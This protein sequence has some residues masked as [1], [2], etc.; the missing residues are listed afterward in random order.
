MYSKN[1][2]GG[3]IFK[4]AC[5]LPLIAACAPDLPQ[6]L[7]VS[8]GEP[9]QPVPADEWRPQRPTLDLEVSYP[10][11]EADPEEPERRTAKESPGLIDEADAPRKTSTQVLDLSTTPPETVEPEPGSVQWSSGIGGPG[12]DAAMDVAADGDG[13]F[14][15]VGYFSGVVDFGCGAHT[16]S[17]TYD[18]F[19]VKQSASGACVWSRTAGSASGMSFADA[20]AIGASGAIYVIGSFYDSVAFSTASLVSNG[21][22][23]VFVAE[24]S[25]AGAE[26][27]ASSFGGTNEDY[28]YALDADASGI[29]LGGAFYGDLTVGETTLTSNGDADAFAVKLDLSGTPMWAAG[30][31][32]GNWDAVNDLALDGTGVVIAGS[33]QNAV[34][35]GGGTVTAAGGHD[36][37]I[38]RRTSDGTF[39]WSATFGDTDDDVATSVDL[40]DAGSMFVGG[41][42]SGTLDLGGGPLV[43]TGS[44]SGFVS[45]FDSD[46]FFQWDTAVTATT[47]V[48]TGVNADGAGGVVLSG[49]SSADGVVD[50]AMAM[51]VDATGSTAWTTMVGETGSAQATRIAMDANAVVISGLF[52]SS[53]LAG[54]DVLTSAGGSDSLLTSFN[55]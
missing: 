12:L 49:R 42:F 7:G 17:G 2:L 41:Y 23:D 46:G 18:L 39:D 45:K 40:D 19:V 44:Y 34:D 38:T 11:A 53:V 16:S 10:A 15:S 24:Y 3:S 8:E 9:R 5:L 35:F 50:M 13:N 29:Y 55:P 47:C 25:A 30:F 28:V 31:G 52:D 54:S 36:V 26:Q 27:W 43:S 20:V 6:T 14:V 48:V 22:S 4:M 32:S 51:R 33:F 37:F 1:Q 21:G